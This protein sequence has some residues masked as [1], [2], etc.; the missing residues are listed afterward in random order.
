M[1]SPRKGYNKMIANYFDKQY[2]LRFFEM[3]VF[4][5]V[6]STTILTSL[7]ETYKVCATAKTVWKPRAPIQSPE[8]SLQ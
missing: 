3:N 5:I 1:Q 6:L 8:L 7:E 4:C 2:E